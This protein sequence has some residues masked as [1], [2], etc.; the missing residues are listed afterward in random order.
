MLFL[1]DSC[2]LTLHDDV[3]V[4]FSFDFCVDSRTFASCKARL[5][6]RPL[7][8]RAS[9]RN[10]L[11]RNNLVWRDD[12]RPCRLHQGHRQVKKFHFAWKFLYI[13]FQHRHGLFFSSV[14][15]EDYY[16]TFEFLDKLASNLQTKL[17]AWQPTVLDAKLW[18]HAR[19]LP[20][21][22]ALT[23]REFHANTPLVY[24]AFCS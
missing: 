20:P 17:S 5:M 9:T 13:I 15:R 1:R 18:A 12:E 8:N 3:V 14:K 11:R 19:L 10:C 21:R 2:A 22:H 4:D 6:W 7:S 24:L 16:N 23:S